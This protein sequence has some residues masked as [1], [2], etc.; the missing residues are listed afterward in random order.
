MPAAP[1]VIV[2]F[3]TNLHFELV[4]EVHLFLTLG[5]FGEDELGEY[6]VAEMKIEALSG[7]WQIKFKF[8]DF[9][10][11]IS[12]PIAW[13][14]SPAEVAAA[15]NASGIGVW[16]VE[17]LGVMHYNVKMHG[18]PDFGGQPG[19]GPESIN[20]QGELVEKGVYDEVHFTVPLEEGCSNIPQPPSGSIDPS[21]ADSGAKPSGRPVT[22]SLG[23]P[24]TG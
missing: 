14:A 13:N 17:S 1:N 20:L 8:N 24:V 15:L 9:T 11:G 16:T 12:D 21:G 7:T 5:G 22:G 23:G 4:S 6:L 19:M 2:T 3:Y 18:P 10:E